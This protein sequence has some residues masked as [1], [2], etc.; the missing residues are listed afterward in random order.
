MKKRGSGGTI[1]TSE[2]TPQYQKK[3]KRLENNIVE[4]TSISSDVIPSKEPC[5][6]PQGHLIFF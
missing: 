1:G 5:L 6:V 3:T 4:T 2:H